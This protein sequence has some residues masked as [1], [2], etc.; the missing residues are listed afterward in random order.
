MTGDAVHA[1][2]LRC[3]GSTAWA[4]EMRA[5]WPFTGLDDARAQGLAVWESL[6][7]ADWREAFAAHPRI[8][9]RPP[10]G[11]Q[12]RGEQSLAEHADTAVLLEIA[13]GNRV[14][15]DRFGMTYIVRASG[16]DAPTMLAILR[17]RLTN[18]P[19]TELG[20]AAEQQWE[21]TSL[22][23]ATVVELQPHP[24]ELDA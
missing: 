15:E 24:Q 21:I 3:C 22:R 23:L 14:Y 2:L 5:R 18:D 7:E 6:T 13:D 12:E 19:A 9:D 20:V 1:E 10:T 11:S 4:R 17:E 8:G 16:R